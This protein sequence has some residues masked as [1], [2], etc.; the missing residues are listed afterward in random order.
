[1]LIHRLPFP[2][3][4]GAKLRAALELQWLASRHDVWCA[5]LWESEDAVNPAGVAAL[6]EMRAVC[7]DIAAI[8]LKTGPASLRAL[9]SLMTGKAASEG[10]FAPR[11]L[12]QRVM[13]WSRE[14]RFD[15]VLAFSSSMAPLAL[16]VPARRHV[17]DMVDL[18]SL[19]W[20]QCAAGEEGLKRHIHHIEASRLAKGEREWIASFDTTVLVNAREANCVEPALRHR[21]R[22][23]ETGHLS[24]LEVGPTA[25]PLCNEP[26]VGLMGAMDYG[27]NIEAACWFAESM[28]PRIRKEVG[29]AQ[30]WIVGRSPTRS[31]RNLA[32]IEG[33]TVTGTVPAVEPYLDRMQVHVAPLRVARGVQTKVVA[34]MAAGR[35][36]VV[37]PCVAEGIGAVSGQDY[38]VAET[39][40]LFS[41]AVIDLLKHRER[42]QEIADNGR[43]FVAR[44]FDPRKGLEELESLLV[45]STPTAVEAA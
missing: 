41:T 14:V 25:T 45:A 31:V 19:K 24:R 8:P 17:L 28:W 20:A 36:C 13:A 6:N 4:R 15:A 12:E 16:R 5:G 43:S 23:I 33:V 29:D 9:G 42:A 11:A 1:M 37:T 22:I 3:D 2:A 26:I 10:Y 35:P 39:P 30:W 27:P 18:D 38:L 40:E 7:R 21:V 34:A 32:E 44:R